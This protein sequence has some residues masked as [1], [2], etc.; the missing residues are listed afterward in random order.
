MNIESRAFSNELNFFSMSIQLCVKK[1]RYEVYNYRSVKLKRIYLPNTAYRACDVLYTFIQ[2]YSLSTIKPFNNKAFQR[3]S[4]K[5]QNDTNISH[6][7]KKIVGWGW[8]RYRD[9]CS[10]P[11]RVYNLMYAWYWSCPPGACQLNER[12]LWGLELMHFFFYSKLS[13]IYGIVRVC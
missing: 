1:L 10:R 7:N 12:F 11:I 8:A 6:L 9:V 3:Q 4:F 13:P 2:R 5:V